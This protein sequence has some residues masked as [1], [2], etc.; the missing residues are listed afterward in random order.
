MGRLV[1]QVSFL[2]Y[3]S[4]QQLLPIL[5]GVSVEEWP[6]IKIEMIVVLFLISQL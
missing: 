6:S 1:G 3:I 5:E 4:Q 2:I